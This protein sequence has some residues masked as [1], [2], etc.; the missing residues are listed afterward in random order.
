MSLFA[1]TGIFWAP[2]PHWKTLRSFSITTLR[3]QGM[4]KTALE[5]KVYQEVEQCMDHFLQP[6]LGR[7]ISMKQALSKATCNVVS[8]MILSKRFDY[9]DKNLDLILQL[10]EE[11]ISLIGKL[12][13]LENIP[14][15][16]MFLRSTEARENELY[17]SIIPQLLQS[18]INEHKETLEREHPRDVIDRYIL[19]SESSE[20]GKT[21][22]FAG[23]HTGHFLESNQS[24]NKR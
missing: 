18:F 8:Q 10:F 7:A 17:E 19:H 13:L 9:D 3:E 11:S 15:S 21:A 16:K 2:F 12:A 1:F 20:E 14:F 22:S 4:G 6:N 23:R 5:P 24:R